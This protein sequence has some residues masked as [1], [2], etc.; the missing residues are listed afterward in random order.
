[1]Y[2]DMYK[3]ELFMKTI[4]QAIGTMILEVVFACLAL[5]ILIVGL[6]LFEILDP[7]VRCY[8]TIHMHFKK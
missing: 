3:M 6:I 7:I 8:D 5:P 1:M 4:L 2:K